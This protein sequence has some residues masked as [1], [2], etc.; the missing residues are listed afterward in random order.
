MFSEGHQIWRQDVSL[1]KS[2][3][4][5]FIFLTEHVNSKLVTYHVSFFKR[6]HLEYS[7]TLKDF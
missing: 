2:T 7:R 6:K 1:L 3:L 5:L 4:L